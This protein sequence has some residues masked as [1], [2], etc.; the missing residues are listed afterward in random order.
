MKKLIIIIITGAFL[1]INAQHTCF[2][3]EPLKTQENQFYKHL[4][5]IEKKLHQKVISEADFRE[6]E[7]T[8]LHIMNRTEGKIFEIAITL[9]EN[10]DC[11]A[12]I[13]NY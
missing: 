7:L 12:K 1:I 2:A 13:I 11:H 10:R 6:I 9:W 3:Q 4:V 5:I 8:L